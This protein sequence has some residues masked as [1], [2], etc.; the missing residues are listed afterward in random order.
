MQEFFQMGGYAYYVWSS[1]AF[2]ILGISYLYYSAKISEKKNFNIAKAWNLRKTGK[3][4]KLPNEKS[5][6]RFVFPL[7][8]LAIPLIRIIEINFLR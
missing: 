6:W 1:F 3:Q 5:I 7:L 4:V 2:G 8:A